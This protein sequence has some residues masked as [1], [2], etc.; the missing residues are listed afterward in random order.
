MQV[1]FTRSGGSRY[2][3]TIDREHGPRL[4]PRYGPGYDEHMPHDIAH[5]VVEEQLGI[6]L[7]VF[8]QIAAGDSG[9][10]APN[11][12]ER[13]A[14]DRRRGRSRIAVEGRPDIIRSELAVQ[15]C[16]PEWLRRTGRGG[17]G[18]IGNLDVELAPA[19]L[20]RVVG[21][22][23]EV[24]GRWREIA[25]G[26]SLT[27]DWPGGAPAGSGRVSGSRPARSRGRSPR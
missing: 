23:E 20:E 13:R 27:L 21:R 6:R 8:G 25:V 10:F 19:E 26:G 15:R 1:T 4:Q 2:L 17:H 24:A 14:S 12:S 5:F 22:L 16:V 3:V 9:L 11:P 7:G 18:P